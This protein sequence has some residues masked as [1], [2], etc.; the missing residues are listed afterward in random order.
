M[1]CMQMKIYVV[2]CG[3]KPPYTINIK[4]LYHEIPAYSR[5]VYQGCL[6]LVSSERFEAGSEVV[7]LNRKRKRSK[8]F[9][10]FTKPHL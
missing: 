2:A 7:L 1:Q 8:S 3:V 6:F 5:P 4:Y 10:M 9:Y